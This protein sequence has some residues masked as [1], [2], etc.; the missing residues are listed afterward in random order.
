MALKNQPEM[1]QAAATAGFETEAET[2]GVATKVEAPEAAVA[3]AGVAASTAIAKASAGAVS[4]QV[5]SKLVIAFSGHKDVF[6]TATVSALSMATPRITGEQGSLKKNRTVKLGTSMR[7]EVI[8]WNHRW[9]LGC[10]EQ[11]MNDEMKQLFRV[12]YDNKTVDGEGCS[13]EDYINSL[14]AQGYEKAKVSP[15]CDLF[16]Y[17]TWTKDGGDIAPDDRELALV[18]LS[19][20]SLGNFTAFCVSRGLLESRGTVQPS[21]MIEITAEDNTK[22]SMSYTNMSFKAVK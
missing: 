16:G 15:Y 4:T 12:S 21:E 22:G 20:T 6:D 1:T 8:S 7:L 14:K 19:S 18:Q 2:A 13:I 11:T 17:I 3:A 9:A 10:G 5:R